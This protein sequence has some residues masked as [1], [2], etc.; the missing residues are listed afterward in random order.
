MLAIYCLPTIIAV[1]R[2]H[3]SRVPIIL[4]NILL[5]WTAIGWIIALIWSFTSPAS[6]NVVIQPPA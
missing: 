5:G 6:A 2:N 1:Y 3:H 4:V